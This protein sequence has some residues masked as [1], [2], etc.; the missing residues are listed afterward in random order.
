MN[1][2]ALSV[3]F[4]LDGKPYAHAY[5]HSRPMVGDIV[6]LKSG[7]PYI[8]KQVIWTSSD[9]ITLEFNGCNVVIEKVIEEGER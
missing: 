3:D 4:H 6:V 8:V 1:N 5:I 7:D 2:N 9:L